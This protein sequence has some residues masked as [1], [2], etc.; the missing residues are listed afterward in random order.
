M[1]LKAHKLDEAQQHAER[2]AE[3]GSRDPKLLAA[4]HAVLADIALARHDSEAARREAALVLESDPATVLPL[5]VDARL[6][7]DESNYADALPIFERANAELKK[8]RGAAVADLH[9]LTGDT[10]L[11]AG[12]YP[13]AEAQLRE[14][15]RNFPHNVRASAALAMLYQS[16]GQLESAARVV[17]DL[18]RITPTEGSYA[19][20]A[21]LWTSLGDRKQAA[22]VRVEARRLFTRPRA[23]H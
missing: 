15:L 10:L 23:S 17:S 1:S 4:A 21:K 18:L 5:Y 8:A 19:L 20:A 16:T 9:Y 11:Q 13:E 2:A 22:A 14:E 6:L 12:R 3:V 7:Y